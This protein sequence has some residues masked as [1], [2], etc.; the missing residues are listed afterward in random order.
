MGRKAQAKRAE[1]A[2]KPKGRKTV[3]GSR[4]TRVMQ[5]L[6]KLMPEV[7]TKHQVEEMVA[8][9][10]KPAAVR[11]LYLRLLGSRYE[12]LPCCGKAELCRAQNAQI[13]HGPRCP[14]KDKQV[15]L[16]DSVDGLAATRYGRVTRA[17]ED[18]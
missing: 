4:D 5:R 7:T 3:S 9:S 10:S 14:E 11:K 1:K 8:Q 15:V 13:E 16:P 12:E 18:L 17:L 2:T 6:K